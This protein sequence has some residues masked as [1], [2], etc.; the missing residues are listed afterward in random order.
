[1]VITLAYG[2]KVYIGTVVLGDG[3]HINTESRIRS[4]TYVIAAVLDGLCAVDGHNLPLLVVARVATPTAYIGTIGHD[5]P[6]GIQE[7]AVLVHYIETTI[8]SVLKHPH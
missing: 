5:S 4:T 2:P 8:A 3:F 1:M 7:A 6:V